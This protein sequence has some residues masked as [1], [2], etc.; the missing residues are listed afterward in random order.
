M[1]QEVKTKKKISTTT[2]IM[3]GVLVGLIWGLV[4]PSNPIVNDVLRTIGQL[5][6]RLI[7]MSII[8]LVMGQIIQAIG[9]LKM[10]ELGKIGYKTLLVFFSS[11]L[12]AAAFAALIGFL[13]KPGSGIDIAAIQAG[14]A[15]EAT[16]ITIFDTILNFFP[17]N[18]IKAMSD[19]N[20]MQVIIFALFF[21]IAIS[22]LNKDNNLKLYDLIKEFNAVILRVVTMVMRVAP[23]G[24]FALIASSIGSYGIQVVIPLAKYLGIFALIDLLFMTIYILVVWMVTGVTPAETVRGLGRMSMLAVATGSSA[25]TMPTA[26]Q[27][28]ENKLGVSKKVSRIMMPLG[29][30]LNSNGAAI[31][32]VITLITISQMYGMAFTPA[33]VFYMIVLC[34]LASV[35]NA[36]VPGAGIVSLTIVVPQMGLP[37]ESIALFAGVEIFVGMLRTIV[38]VDGDALSAMLVAKSEGVLNLAKVRAAHGKSD[39]ELAEIAAAEEAAEALHQEVVVKEP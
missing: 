31:H 19:G 9:G 39:E 21:G 10:K 17:S 4:V 13:L 8:L 36:V 16:K 27:D 5:F 11:S 6:L 35:A 38:N 2:W 30:T 14:T 18:V 33:N 26:M 12:L 28:V 7:Q 24:V 3:I 20:I 29:V 34:T 32:M 37:L 1:Q 23:F 25:I 22:F 15:V